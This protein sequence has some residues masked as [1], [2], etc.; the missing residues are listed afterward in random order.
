MR[1]PSRRACS[2]TS[3]I[4]ASLASCFRLPTTSVGGE[5]ICS[6]TVG[7]KTN[8]NV[9]LD[10][11]FKIEPNVRIRTS[12]R[13]LTDERFYLPATISVVLG[14]NVYPKVMQPG[15]LK[16]QD[17]LPVAQNTVFGWVLSG[18]CHQP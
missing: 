10:L 18:A 5:Q 6:A 14:A 4:D 16:I 11:A 7:S 17:G 2:P 15:F 3:C 8:A 13:Q 12:I 1:R 9:R